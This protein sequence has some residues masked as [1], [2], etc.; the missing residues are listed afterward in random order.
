MS[1]S[2]PNPARERHWVCAPRLRTQRLALGLS[3]LDVVAAHRQRGIPATGR[4]VSG[5]Y[6]IRW[7]D[8]GSGP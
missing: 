5:S 8:P 7:S 4:T 6:C 1:S 2:K 3:Q